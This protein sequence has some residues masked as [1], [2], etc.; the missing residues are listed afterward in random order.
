M[1]GW[2]AHGQGPEE[3]KDFHQSAWK[4]LGNVKCH[5]GGRE[6]MGWCLKSNEG[7]AVSVN[8]GGSKLEEGCKNRM[9]TGGS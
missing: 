3:V 4:P 7:G 6:E 8:S 5:E 2:W 9:E 1:V